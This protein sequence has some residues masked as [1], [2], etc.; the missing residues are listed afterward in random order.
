MRVLI[1]T[2]GSNGDVPP[3]TGLGSRLRDAG[4][5]VT[6]AT[7]EP[8]RA[9][10]ELPFLALPGDLRRILPQARGQDGT[11]SGTGPRALLRLLRIARPLVAELGDGIVDAVRQTRAEAVLLSTVVAPL[12]YQVAQAAGIPWAGVFL[13]EVYPT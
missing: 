5:E 2:S 13:K 12:G 3:Y 10:V 4:H 6:L 11:G 8:F 1:V 7:H 9:A